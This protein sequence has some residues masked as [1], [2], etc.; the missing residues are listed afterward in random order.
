MNTLLVQSGRGLL[1]NENIGY[2]APDILGGYTHHGDGINGYSVDGIID[3]TYTVL[4]NDGFDPDYCL[5]DRRSL[6]STL[7]VG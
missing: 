7:S 3:G 1:C 6:T 5:S 2:S 4:D